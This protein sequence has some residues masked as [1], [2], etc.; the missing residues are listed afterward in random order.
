MCRKINNVMKKKTTTR[1]KGRKRKEE[2]NMDGAHIDVY[3]VERMVEVW[4][5]RVLPIIR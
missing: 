5:Q 3:S 1:E 4:C 2:S